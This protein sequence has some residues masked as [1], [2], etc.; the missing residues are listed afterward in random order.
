MTK[1]EF[2]GECSFARIVHTPRGPGILIAGEVIEIA[3]SPT[4]EVEDG[5]VEA[6]VS[7]L[8]RNGREATS[9][10]NMD[11]S[12]QMQDCR[13]GRITLKTNG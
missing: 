10:R 2:V 5:I 3:C 11:L 4:N 9:F 8:R 12:G 13:I 1:D 7:A 6:L